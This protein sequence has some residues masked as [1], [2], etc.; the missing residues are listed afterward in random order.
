MLDSAAEE[1]EIPDDCA[2]HPANESAEN[3]PIAAVSAATVAAS[4]V[5]CSVEAAA[6][7]VA[8]GSATAAEAE[9]TAMA[10]AAAAAEAEALVDATSEE[11]DAALALALQREEDSF[12]AVRACGVSVGSLQARGKDALWALR[13][14]SVRH[15]A[16]RG[17]EIV[18]GDDGDHGDVAG[19][20]DAGHCRG[21]KRNR[22]DRD[23]SRHG[24]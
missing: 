18:E 15:P 21:D 13:H 19:G 17:E 23:G 7:T 8:P 20:G 6:A 2:Q 10:V 9:A 24:R 12:G 14:R 5:D 3:A 1:A 4:F 11:A 22:G 16:T